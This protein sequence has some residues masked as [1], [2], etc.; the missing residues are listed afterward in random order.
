MFRCR[1]YTHTTTTTT[2]IMKKEMHHFIHSFSLHT[3]QEEML[4]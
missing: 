1:T 2:I 3:L 4:D